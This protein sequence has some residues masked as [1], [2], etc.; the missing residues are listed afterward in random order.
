MRIYQCEKCK[1]FIFTNEELNCE[2]WVELIAGTVE[3]SKE[4][5]IPVVSKK[6]KQVKV[7]VGSVAHPMTAEHLIEWVLIETEQGYQVKYLTAESSPVASFSLAD[8]DKL[9]AVY[10]YCNLHGLWRA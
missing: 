6:C 10:A 9:K 1:K 5:H 8:G 4:K 3:A 2:G 7:D